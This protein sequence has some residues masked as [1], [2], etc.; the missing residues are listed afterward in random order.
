VQ[1]NSSIEIA[2]GTPYV[3]EDRQDIDIVDR[4]RF[5]IEIRE[6]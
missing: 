4:D 1:T 5:Y 6:F 2:N 3:I